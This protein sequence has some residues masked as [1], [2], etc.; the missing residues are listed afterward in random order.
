LPGRVDA[1]D[2][3]FTHRPKLAGRAPTRSGRHGEPRESDTGG[4]NLG[5]L[6][7]LVRRYIVREK[8]GKAAAVLG[9]GCER[10]TAG[11]CAKCPLAAGRRRAPPT[12]AMSEGR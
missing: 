7:G 3:T 6:A 10:A 8:A 1:N 5:E 12:D 9:S 4:T 11:D 2:T